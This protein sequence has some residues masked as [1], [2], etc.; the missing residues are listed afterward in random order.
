MDKTV[1]D[2]AAAVAGIEDGMS[3]MI[4]GFGGSGAPIEL[5]HAL[6]DRFK[7]TGSPGNLTVIN[8]NAPSSPLIFQIGANAGDT[9]AITIN[10]GTASSGFSA[11][12][13]A[14]GTGTGESGTGLDVSQ[15]STL[16]AINSA[17]TKVSSSRGTLGALQNRLEHTINNLNVSVENL[18]A[19]ESRVR[20][21]DMASEMVS[22]PSQGTVSANRAR[23][24]G[25]SRTPAARKPRMGLIFSRLNSG[26]ASSYAFR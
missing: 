24:S 22:H 5:I 19:S 10:S 13:L 8:N 18:T 11:A 20:D 3:L 6:I 23:P 1:P 7:A 16:T 17:I 25:P 14:V 9:L 26:R 4:G 15:S 2:L 12:D 21:T